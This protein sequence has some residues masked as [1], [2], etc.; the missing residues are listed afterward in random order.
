MKPVDESK[1]LLRMPF[2]L[3][4][5]LGNFGARSRISGQRMLRDQHARAAHLTYGSLTEA[6]YDPS[7]R[8]TPKISP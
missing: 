5:S 2:A 3:K 8:N 1:M 6:L 7:W 4:A